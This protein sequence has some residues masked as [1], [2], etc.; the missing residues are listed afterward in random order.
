[1]ARNKTV[2]SEKELFEKNNIQLYCQRYETFEYSQVGRGRFMPGLSIIDTLANIG[3]N[4]VLS[5]IRK[6]N[7]LN[8]T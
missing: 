5:L 2:L 3:I 7:E 6:N 1:M 8:D 4:G